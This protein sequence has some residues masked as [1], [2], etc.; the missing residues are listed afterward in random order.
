MRKFELCFRFEENEN[1]YLIPDLLDK[2]Q[3]REA[4]A[5]KPIECL[6]FRYEYPI[7]PEG[8][9]P[10]FIVRTYVL[11]SHQ[12]RWRTGVIL[13]F[14]D[15][16]ALVKADRQDRCVT[17][18]V[19]GPIASRRRLLAIIRYDFERIHSSFKFKPQEKVPVPKH[20]AVSVDYKK[21]LVREDHKQTTF[22]VFTGEGLLTLNV[23]DLLNGVDLEDGRQPV[24]AMDRQIQALKLFYSYAH[25][26]ET[27]CKQL[28]T[29][30]K[31][32]QRQKLI[33]SWHDRCITAGGEWKKE[34]DNN[35]NQADIILLL[36]SVDFIASEYCYD[37]QMQKAM[38][39]HHR[40]E[41]RVIPIILRPADWSETPF[42]KLEG[43]PTDAKAVTQWRDRDD[44]WLNVE[45]GIKQ[46]VES[47]KARRRP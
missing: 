2:Q 26:D 15:N 33:Q 8:L 35:L 4:E 19:K 47:I 9:L 24:S 22:D 40:G 27:L 41:A 46:V 1:R 30:L 37:N 43:L 7:L 36:I 18:S 38:E 29:H 3:P 14:E 34:I 23:R 13:A 44:A 32:L 11:S 42:S 20:P 45:T 39:R 28:A 5:F 17:I 10:R 12:L 21:L 16:R 31:L 25:E 6:N